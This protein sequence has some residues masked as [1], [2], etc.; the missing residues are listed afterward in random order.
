MNLKPCPFCGKQ[1]VYKNFNRKYI[2]W[3]KFVDFDLK[4]KN[5]LCHMRIEL[6][7]VMSKEEAAE[8]WNRRAK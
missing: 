1:P 5:K 8:A 3:G 2:F 6:K 4:C 7:R